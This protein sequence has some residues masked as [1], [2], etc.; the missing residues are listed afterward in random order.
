MCVLG[1]GWL[2]GVRIGKRDRA[3]PRNKWEE[4]GYSEEEGMLNGS[5]EIGPGLL[6]PGGDGGGEGVRCQ[7]F[8]VYWGPPET[9]PGLRAKT[10]FLKGLA[11][12][13]AS[14][15]FTAP[16]PFQ[17]NHPRT[18]RCEWRVRVK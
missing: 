9:G 15:N 1:A 10:W 3:T 5:P 14:R 17:R 7:T 12:M 16:R 4:M 8:A 13:V 18:L 11:G 2:W 6:C